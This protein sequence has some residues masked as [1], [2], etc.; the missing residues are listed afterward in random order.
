MVQTNECR[1]LKM[2]FQCYLITIIPLPL[3]GYSFA[4]QVS[5]LYHEKGLVENSLR[6][7]CQLLYCSRFP[8][9]RSSSRHHPRKHP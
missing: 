5:K 8:L 1:H 6:F 3:R 4:I 9:Q 7:V 2:T